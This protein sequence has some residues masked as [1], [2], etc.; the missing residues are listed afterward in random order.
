MPPKTVLTRELIIDGAIRVVRTGGPEAL[1]ARS[2]AAALGCSTQPIYSSFRSIDELVDA[3][4][5][6]ALE[7]ALDHELPAPDPESEFLGIGLTYLDFS[8]SEPNLFRL[9][10]THGRERLSPSR[11]NWPFRRLTQ[12]M[13]RDTALAPL[14]EER[15][16]GLLRTMFIYTHGLASLATARPTPEELEAERTLL[17]SVGG[18]MIALAVME[19]RGE[20]DLE[21]AARRFHA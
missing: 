4:V 18:R 15:L 11:E 13:R 7:S 1:S 14:S 5:D 19:E 21:K 3:T 12:Q 8:R 10:M 20:F 16:Q 6:R 9:L 17:R 2:V